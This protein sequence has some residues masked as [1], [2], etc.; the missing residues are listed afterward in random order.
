MKKLDYYKTS[1]LIKRLE[2]YLS[3]EKSNFKENI[4]SLESKTKENIIS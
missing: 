2:T 4:I 1:E 3:I